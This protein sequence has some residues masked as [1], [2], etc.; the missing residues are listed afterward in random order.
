MGGIHA[1]GVLG[2]VVAF[3]D[4]GAHD[5]AVAHQHDSGVVAELKS[6][7]NHVAGGFREL[8]KADIL[9]AKSFKNLSDPDG[10]L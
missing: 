3:P 4:Q 2:A 10:A 5:L 8:N 7:D 1:E 9:S 6:K